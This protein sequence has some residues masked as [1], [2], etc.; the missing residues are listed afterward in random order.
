MVLINN[1]AI[2]FSFPDLPGKYFIVHGFDMKKLLK[3][4]LDF[5]ALLVLV[6]AINILQWQ[7][8][9]SWHQACGRTFSGYFE[10]KRKAELA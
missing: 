1:K 6:F 5:R 8:S 9:L 7:I 2:L 10:N 3:F 4:R